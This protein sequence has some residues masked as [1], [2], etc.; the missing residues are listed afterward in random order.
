MTL[1]GKPT[2]TRSGLTR[3]AFLKSR[4]VKLVVDAGQ[5]D[6]ICC[7]LKHKTTCHSEH[8]GFDRHGRR[9][10]DVDVSPQKGCVLG[11]HA[12][13]LTGGFR[14]GSSTAIRIQPLLQACKGVHTRLSA[15]NGLHA[16]DIIYSQRPL[17]SPTTRSN[18]SLSFHHLTAHLP[19]PFS[20]QTSP[21]PPVANGGDLRNFHYDFNSFS[22][23]ST[24]SVVSPFPGPGT[25]SFDDSKRTRE[26]VT[27]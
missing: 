19:P 15:S 14:G 1:P 13:N 6:L 7:E 17:S 16:A 24:I 23:R 12:L 18:S 22:P 2:P 10:A 9:V 20:N 11:R 5:D 26:R 25:P 8:I 27:H 3:W 4:H 21:S